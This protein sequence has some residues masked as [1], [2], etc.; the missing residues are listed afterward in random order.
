[1]AG[2]SRVARQLCGIRQLAVPQQVGDRLERLRRGELLYRVS[3]VQERVRL[4]VDLRDGG[5]VGDHPGEAA[6]DLVLLGHVTPS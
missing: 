1:M 5:R 4:G 2:P 3:P 6:V